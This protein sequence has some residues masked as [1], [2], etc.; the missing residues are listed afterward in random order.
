M[1]PILVM[2][3][4]ALVGVFFAGALGRSDQPARRALPEARWSLIADL[5]ENTFGRVTGRVRAL[6]ETTQAPLS[7]RPCVCY[8]AWVE[9]TG[10]P[11]T[12]ILSE[13]RGVPFVIEDETGRAIVDPTDARIT[14]HFD[15]ESSTIAAASATPAQDALLARHG[16]TSTGIL[17]LKPMCFR[18]GIVEVGETIAV[19]GAGIRERDAE[20]TGLAGYRDEPTLLRFTSSPR[21]PLVISDD[22]STLGP[23]PE[24]PSGQSLSV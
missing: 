11:R 24:G 4:M 2:A 10:R 6:G 19:L 22:P 18:E 5:P 16:Q 21:E 14:L 1:D 15:H 23:S 20:R 7:G 12:L 3:I 17:G 9:T 13:R 8:V